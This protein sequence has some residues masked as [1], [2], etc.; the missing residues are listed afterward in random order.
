MFTRWVR[1]D[2]GRFVAETITGEVVAP[3]FDL[4]FT[5]DPPIVVS[6]VSGSHEGRGL[7]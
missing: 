3:S 5:E 1:Q 7:I 4:P 6:I 2:D